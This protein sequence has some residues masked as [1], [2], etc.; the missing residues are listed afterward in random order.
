MLL[1][2]LPELMHGASTMDVLQHHARSALNPYA[3]SCSILQTLLYTALV[4]T[5][6]LCLNPC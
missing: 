2:V 3:H 4:E 5:I 1:V 6:V